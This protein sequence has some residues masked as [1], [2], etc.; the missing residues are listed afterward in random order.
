MTDRVKIMI[1]TAAGIRTGGSF[2]EVFE[3]YARGG[4]RW[5]F[6]SPHDDDIVIGSGLLLQQAVAE[7]VKIKVVITTDGSLG[8]IE[9]DQVETIKE[10]RRAETLD[11]FRLLSITD[12]EWLDFPDAGLA[13]HQGRRKA[14]PGDPNPVAGFTGIENSYTYQIRS[15]RPTRIFVPAGSDY[16]PDHKVVHQELLISTFHGTTG[17]WPELGEPAPTF[18]HVYEIAIYC[19]FTREP[20]IRL[21]A[22]RR[23][24]E[25]KLESIEAY[26]S[27]KK[28]IRA[29]VENLR[30]AGPVEYFTDVRFAL[31]DPSVYDGLFRE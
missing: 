10:I 6:V 7:G 15:F 9:R 2:A 18:P 20:D 1:R 19:D 31:Y 29:M 22:P 13:L 14:K 3:D 5:L 27:Q 12:V 23:M 28:I 17:I 21:E 11:S 30:S 16:H 24:L 26:V 25:R 8:Y 4:E